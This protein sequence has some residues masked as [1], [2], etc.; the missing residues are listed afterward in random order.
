MDEYHPKNPARILSSLAHSYLSLVSKQLLYNSITNIGL[1]IFQDFFVTRAIYLLN[2]GY[3]NGIAILAGGCL[4]AFLSIRYFQK[5]KLTMRNIKLKAFCVLL[6]NIVITMLL[7][8][9]IVAISFPD[10]ISVYNPFIKQINVRNIGYLKSY[11]ML[12]VSVLLLLGVVMNSLVFTSPQS[13]IQSM[14]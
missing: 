7:S 12:E 5:M 1:C 3:L 11:L 6:L 9:I 13:T 10:S 4:S 14:V 8:L 2:R